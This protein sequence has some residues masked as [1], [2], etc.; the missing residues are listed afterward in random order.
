MKDGNGKW[1]FTPEY[2]ANKYDG[3][4]EDAWIGFLLESSDEYGHSTRT[5]FRPFDIEEQK[6]ILTVGTCLICHEENSAVMSNSLEE[7]FDKYVLKISDKC[8]LPHW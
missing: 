1:K 3:L 2:A 4:P 6:Q 8:V 7:E 5:N